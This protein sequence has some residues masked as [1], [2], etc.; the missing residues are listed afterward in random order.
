MTQA[1]HIK[2]LQSNTECSYK[3]GEVLH[4]CHTTQWVD[5]F[6]VKWIW[7]R[8]INDCQDGCR[9]DFCNRGGWNASQSSW[10]TRRTP[11]PVQMIFKSFLSTQSNPYGSSAPGMSSAGGRMSI[12]LRFERWV[13]FMCSPNF[14]TRTVGG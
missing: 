8:K 5:C 3:G 1:R 2:D 7:I 13:G 14:P 10:V 11:S 9:T 12:W 6:G 4:L